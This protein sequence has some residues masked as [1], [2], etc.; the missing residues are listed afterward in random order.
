MKT[1][2]QKELE[3][4]RRKEEWKNMSLFRKAFLIILLL[5]G[6]GLLFSSCAGCIKP[7]IG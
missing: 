1:K 7:F 2:R 3:E 6:F 5:W 4:Q